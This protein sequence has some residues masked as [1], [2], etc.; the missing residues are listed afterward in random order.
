[1]Q[2]PLADKDSEDETP[3]DWMNVN[4]ASHYVR[5][6]VACYSWPYYLYMNSI[7]GVNDLHCSASM[8]ACCCC[9]CKQEESEA[10]EETRNVAEA[11]VEAAVATAAT[12][13]HGLVHGDPSRNH[14]RAFKILASIDECDVVYAN[15][16]NDLFFVPFCILV[17]HTK[18]TVVIAIRG[19][20]S[21]RYYIIF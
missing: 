21:M 17:D 12:I 3:P 5:Y 1:M 16:N 8:L 19:T 2:P 9:C 6:A 11:E 4:E 15:F 13:V 20:L 18:K 14:M 10:T 7:K